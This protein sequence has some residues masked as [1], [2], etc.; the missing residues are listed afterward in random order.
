M[1]RASP[2]QGGGR[3]FK[4]RFPLH[5]GI[6][7]YSSM[8]GGNEAKEGDAIINDSQEYL[9]LIL[10]FGTIPLSLSVLYTKD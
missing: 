5:N 10:F 9:E 6:V 2:C 7:V 1:A 4:S 8:R 3:G